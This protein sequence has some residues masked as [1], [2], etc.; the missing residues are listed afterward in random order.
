MPLHELASHLRVRSP[1]EGATKDPPEVRRRIQEKETTMKPIR[2]LMIAASDAPREMLPL[3]LLQ[4]G[5]RIA[6]E[7]ADTAHLVEQALQWFQPDLV[8]SEA[9]VPALDGIEAL[10]LVRR[11]RPEL[12]FVFV[13]D[14]QSEQQQLDALRQ[15]ALDC[16]PRSDKPRLVAAVRHAL[17]VVH[18]RS[19]RREA[20]RALQ[21]SEIRFRLFMEHMPGA[22]YMKDLDGRF[23]YVNSAARHVIGRPAGDILGKTLRQLFPPDVAAALAFNDERALKVRQPVEAVE[24]TETPYGRRAFL[25]IKFPVL[26]DDGQPLMVGGFSVDITAARAQRSG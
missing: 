23:T 24:E 1:R 5:V 9:G 16:V 19:A 3:D 12:P 7:Q 22:I 17:T 13:S 20:E 25:S 14:R 21:E 4:G 6:T 26:G 8:L 18:E 15:G 2:V 10:Q 11:L